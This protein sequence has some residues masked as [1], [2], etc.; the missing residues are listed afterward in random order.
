LTSGYCSAEYAFCGDGPFGGYGGSAPSSG[1]GSHHGAWPNGE[2]LGLPGGLNL[3]HGTLAD[4]LG[5]SAGTQCEFGQCIPISDNFVGSGVSG[6]LTFDS[7]FLGWWLK[8][9]NLLPYSTGCLVAVSCGPTANTYG[10]DHCIVTVKQNGKYT[11]CQGGPSG[12]V[13]N[14]TLVVGCGPGGAPGPSTF[15]LNDSC[16]SA[17]CI[18]PMAQS[19]NDQKLWYS[20]P[21]QNSNSAA[22]MML[23]KCGL[24]VT[25]PVMGPQ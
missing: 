18:P 1:G 6:G 7:W 11:M 2:T 13:F 24:N 4:L 15:Y 19:I 21:F 8:T 10:M 14:S 23:R 9:L 20:F 3:H 22:G 25:L 16:A 12:K 5:L 17:A